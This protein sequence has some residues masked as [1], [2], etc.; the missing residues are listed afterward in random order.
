MDNFYLVL[1]LPDSVGNIWYASTL[2]GTI[3]L[4][5]QVLFDRE[6]DKNLLLLLTLKPHIGFG[7]LHLIIPVFSFFNEL[8][9]IMS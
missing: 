2:I 9:P 3:K 7:L 1:W 5:W 8:D 6:R 4:M